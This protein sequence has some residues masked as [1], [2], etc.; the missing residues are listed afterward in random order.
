MRRSEYFMRGSAAP[1]PSPA[2]SRARIALLQPTAGLHLAIDPRVPREKQA[3]EFVLSGVEPSMQVE[4]LLDGALV[5]RS[6]G[7]RHLW[8]ITRGAHTLEAVVW[9]EQELVG[10]SERVEFLVR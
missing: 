4:W 1:T 10:R 5:A 3:F 8:Q 7:G 6:A 2:V 9:L